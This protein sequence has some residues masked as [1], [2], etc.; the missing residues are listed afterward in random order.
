MHTQG[1]SPS[2]LH[3]CPCCNVC[4]S[5]P[6]I[7]L[8]LAVLVRLMGWIAVAAGMGMLLIGIPAAGIITWALS[9]VRVRLLESTDSRVKLISEAC[10]K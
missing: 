2:N 10:S 8:L 9:I 6:Q 7:A 3:C 1:K 4:V 5:V